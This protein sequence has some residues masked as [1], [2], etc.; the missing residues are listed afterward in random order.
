MT[1]RGDAISAGTVRM[2]Y[3]MSWMG[4]AFTGV[5]AGLF[6]FAA[7]LAVL[8]REMVAP[9]LGWAGMV[10]AAAGFVGGGAGFYVTEYSSFWNAVGFVGFLGFAAWVL[11]ASV[12]M[13]QRPEVGRAEARQPVFGH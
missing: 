1:H 11:V 8:R 10:I 9:W 13:L 5:V 4:N 2:L 6:L 3:D 7:S 12:A